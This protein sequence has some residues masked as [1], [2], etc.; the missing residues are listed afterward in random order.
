MVERTI[1]DAN[2]QEVA[3]RREAMDWLMRLSEG[4]AAQERADFEAWLN[5]SPAHKRAYKLAKMVWDDVPNTPGLAELEP[6]RGA[7]ANKAVATAGGWRVSSWLRPAMGM[8]AAL[9]V[10]VAAGIFMTIG[11]EP[12]VPGVSHVTAVAETRDLTLADGSVVALG[13]DS[14]IEVDFT[15]RERRV[16]LAAGEAFFS[17]EKDEARP[18]FVIADN[19]VVRVVGTRFNVRRGAAQVDVSVEEGV[20]RVLR[21][22]AASRAPGG[23]LTL[24]AGQSA[25]IAEEQDPAKAEVIIAA[26]PGAW[27]N[28]RLLYD[29]ARLSEIIA[30]ANRYYDGEIVLATADLGALELTAAFKTDQIDEL[31]DGLTTA[32]PVDAERRSGGRIVIRRAAHAR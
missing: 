17:V 14:R 16:L 29:G 8:A 28:G 11:R 6:L 31:I 20:V 21:E 9:V 23:G 13:A 10:F 26:Q 27:R 5:S 4:A 18:F 15:E 30:D 12:A 25:E 7:P 2:G 24:T 19:T 1:N 22:A 3:L 32:L